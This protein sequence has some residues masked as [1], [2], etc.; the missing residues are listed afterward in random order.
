MKLPLNQ[1]EREMFRRLSQSNDGQILA[2]FLERLALKAVDIRNI[3][4]ANLLEEKRGR[5]VAVR[6]IEE[7]VTGR[8]KTLGKDVEPDE[9]E[10][11]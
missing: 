5:E 6:F 11:L 1:Q 4:D 2:G 9:D 10:F 3:P 7:N 8:L